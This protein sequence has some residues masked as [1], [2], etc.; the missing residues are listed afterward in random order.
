MSAHNPTEA[1]GERGTRRLENGGPWI[2]VFTGEGGVEVVGSMIPDLLTF[3]EGFEV[4][5]RML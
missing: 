3:T 2:N 5:W 4:T 1:P